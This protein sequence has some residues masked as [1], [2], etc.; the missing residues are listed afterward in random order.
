MFAYC[1]NC[2]IFRSDLTGEGW[3]LDK[4]NNLV[5]AAE[6]FLSNI[7]LT[8]SFGINLSGTIGCWSFNA[9]VGVSMDTKGNIGFQ[10]SYGGGLSVNPGLNL[11]DPASG[12]SLSLSGYRSVTNAPTI[13]DLQGRGCQIGSSL[14]I[15]IEGVG[16][17]TGRDVLI[18]DAGNRQYYGYTKTIGIGTP[19]MESHVEWSE[20]RNV[21]K[22]INIF[23]KLRKWIKRERM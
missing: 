20:T 2:P 21:G 16:I 18:C 19:G 7:D 13:N 22:P 8:F 6:S 3:L 17:Y 15:P 12:F 23:D 14:A 9:Q 1:E 5:D 4:L 11:E 10:Y